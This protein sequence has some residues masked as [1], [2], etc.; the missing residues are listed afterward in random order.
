VS[1]TLE[2]FDLTPD[3]VYPSCSTYLRWCYPRSHRWLLWFRSSCTNRRCQP[4]PSNWRRPF[5]HPEHLIKLMDQEDVVMKC[6]T[7]RVVKHNPIL[8]GAWSS[9]H[10]RKSG[11]DDQ[12]VLP[13]QL[14]WYPISFLPLG[15]CII[16]RFLCPLLLNLETR[17]LLRER[18]VTPHVTNSLIYFIKS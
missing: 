10:G 17:F 6:N 18:A 15:Q 3:F 14:F 5:F 9:M 11:I 7:S 16:Y 1:F 4:R 2:H 13:F 8:Q 12:E